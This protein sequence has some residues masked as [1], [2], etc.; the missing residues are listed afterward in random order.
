MAIQTFDPLTGWPFWTAVTPTLYILRSADLV[1]LQGTSFVL[2]DTTDKRR[3]AHPSVVSS[4]PLTTSFASIGDNFTGGGSGGSSGG[5]VRPS[6][7]LLY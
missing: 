6:T 3:F 5:I 1:A 2:A 7:G 4:N